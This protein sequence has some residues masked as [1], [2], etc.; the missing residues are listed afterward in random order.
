M[1]TSI[2]LDTLKQALKICKIEDVLI[3]HSNKESQYLSKAV[4][5]F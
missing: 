1:P 2:I 3:F 5:M 4:K